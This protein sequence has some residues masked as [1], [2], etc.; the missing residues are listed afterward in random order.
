MQTRATPREREPAPINGR[1]E[2]FTFGHAAASLMSDL[3]RNEWMLCRC[4]SEP[5]NW[6]TAANYAI[7]APVTLIA[8]LRD[9]IGLLCADAGVGRWQTL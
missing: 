6:I 4:T 2:S 8:A 7:Y 1:I 5:R 9:A 3:I